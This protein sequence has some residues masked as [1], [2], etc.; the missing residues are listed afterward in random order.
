MTNYL[1]ELFVHDPERRFEY[2]EMVNHVGVF[3]AFAAHNYGLC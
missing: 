1:D 3:D 2:E